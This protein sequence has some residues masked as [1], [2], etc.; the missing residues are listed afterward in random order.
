MPV[1]PRRAARELAQRRVRRARWLRRAVWVAAVLA[2]AALLTWVVLL[3]SLLAVRSVEVEGAARTDPAA[4]LAAAAVVSGTPLARLDAGAVADRVGALPAV[5]DVEVVRDW[6][7]AVR[8]VLSERTVAAAVPAGD[9][10]SLV[11][12]GG[13]VLDRVAALPEAVVTLRVP[14]PGPDDPRTDAGLAVLAEVGPE[15]RA[16]L[17]AVRAETARHVVLEL[18]DGREVVWGSP[19]DAAVK[20]PAAVALLRLQTQVVDVS[21]PGVAVTR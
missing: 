20:G 4:V 9:G 8:L 11:D 18:I 7:D 2:P 14:A 5:A 21:S 15:L 6:P 13:A 17:A 3:S 19:G 1:A 10:W 16:Q 12:P